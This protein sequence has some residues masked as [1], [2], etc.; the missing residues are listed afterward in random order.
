MKSLLVT[1][2]SRG[3]GKALA[4]EALKRRYR[5][6]ALVRKAE[7]A[8][9]GTV[10]HIC[11]VRN[12]ELLGKLIEKLAP[13]LD[14]FI[15]NAGI[16]GTTDLRREDCADRV[17]EVFEVNGTATAYSLYK[18]GH[19]WVKLGIRG[20]RMAVISSL[21]VNIGV[22]TKGPYISTKT[23]QLLL[24][25][26]LERELAPMGIHMTTVQPG[27]IDTDMTKKLK[28]R[29]LL[30]TPEQAACEILD[31]IERGVPFIAFPRTLA[32]LSRLG[33]LIPPSLIRAVIS[34][35]PLARLEKHK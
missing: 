34:Q 7:D 29:P 14:I 32:L 31:G 10:T 28:W 13:D 8:L 16:D 21:A 33:G 2:A 5:V 1:G 22:P 18:M 6:H 20:R 26:A 24:G 30:W 4:L 17:A 27:F 19:E 23:A 11:D 35:V 9:A 25:R 12:R 15:A 3:I